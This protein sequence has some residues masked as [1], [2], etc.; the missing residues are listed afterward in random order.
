MKQITA[1]LTT[2]AI[3]ALSITIIGCSQGGS[4][5]IDGPKA[6]ADN[7][8]TA[9]VATDWEGY[10]KLLA[11]EAQE[12]FWNMLMPYFDAVTPRDS[13]GNPIDSLPV[14]N[15]FYNS[16]E[17]FALTEEEFMVEIMNAIFGVAPDLAVTFSGLKSDVVGGVYEGDALCHMVV[18]NTI[19][20]G[21]QSVIEMNVVSAKNI[22]GEWKMMLAPQVRGVAELMLQSVGAR[23]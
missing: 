19:S 21:G 10:A 13:S 17:F 12:E 7:A 18:R 2:L 3:I 9:L 20:F 22:E 16:T 6:A 23:R 15:K 4:A 11:P 1:G 14:L 8:T 5:A